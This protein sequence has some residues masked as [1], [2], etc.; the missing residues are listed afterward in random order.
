MND[1][2]STHLRRIKSFVLREGRLTQGQQRALDTQFPLFG[3]KHDKT[4]AFNFDEIF[5][6]TAPVILE[7]GFGNGESLHQ[8]AVEHADWNFIGIE[9]HGPGVGNLLYQIEQAETQNVRVMRDDAIDVLNDNIPDNSLDRLNLFFPDP[10]HKTRHYKRRIVRD[11][12]LKLVAKKLKS[13]GILHIATDWDDYARHVR[14]K[15]IENALFTEI[16]EHAD[17]KAWLQR[18]TT[19]FEQRGLRLGHRIT[20]LAYR[21]KNKN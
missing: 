8:M 12:W 1:S 2:S 11:E 10:W 17:I 19:K 7:I 5:D 21:K 3:L 18:P 9:V 16:T 14:A 15:I 20:D 4:K 13:D 6:R